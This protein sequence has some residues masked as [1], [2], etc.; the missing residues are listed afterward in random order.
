VESSVQLTFSSDERARARRGLALLFPL[1]AIF[2]AVF[3][4][5][6]A[7]TGN[8]LWIYAPM[9]SVAAASVITRLVLREGFADVSFRFGGRRTLGWL[10]FG[11]VFPP[12]VGA[13]A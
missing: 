10:V 1:V 11:L 9:W 8:P 12:V 6:L 13:V 3:V 5:A 4:T 7:V 2:D